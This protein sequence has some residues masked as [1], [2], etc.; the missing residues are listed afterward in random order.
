M[1]QKEPTTFDALKESEQL[2]RKK[3]IMQAATDL[4]ESKQF[5]EI[6]IRD[7]ARKADIYL[8]LIYKHFHNQDDL[9]LEI[10]IES[11]Q[12]IIS[13]IQ[14][15]HRLKPFTMSELASRIVNDLLENDTYFKLTC[16]FLN[17]GWNNVEIHNKF[18]RFK[19]YFRYSLW[20]LIKSTGVE[21]NDQ[22]F[23]RGFI[24]TVVGI[25]LTIGNDTELSRAE[26]KK[27]MHVLVSHHIDNNFKNFQKKHIS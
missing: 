25:V 14:A 26:Q 3:M 6:S 23:V 9:F 18:L 15:D 8:A 4:M 19:K 7:I 10:L 12:G 20:E 2:A 1:N 5:H 16:N 24:A 21:D 27:M 11:V 13:R 17:R 22:I